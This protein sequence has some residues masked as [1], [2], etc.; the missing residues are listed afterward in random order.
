MLFVLSLGA[1]ERNDGTV[2]TAPK[3]SRQAPA[4]QSPANELTPEEL[5]LEPAPAADDALNATIAT[6]GVDEMSADVPP[7]MKPVD[8]AE[9]KT[10]R[11]DVISETAYQNEN[12]QYMVDLL[13]HDMAYLTIVVATEDGHPIRGAKPKITLAGNSR[14]VPMGE[15]TTR[16]IGEIQIGVVGGKMGSDRVEVTLG[17]RSLSVQI[18]VISL[19]AAG[20]AGLDEIEG[21]L[22]WEALTQA[23][24]RFDEKGVAAYFPPDI[25]AQNGKVVKLIGFMM[26]LVTGET[27]NHFLLTANPP[28]CFFHIPGGPAGAVEVF[29]EKGIEASWDPVVLQ[30]RFETVQNNQVGVIYRLRDARIVSK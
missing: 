12:R 4:D 20:Y 16:D 17:N 6:P 21:G 30:G 9:A 24:L 10:I 13:E 3:F 22:R 26:P 28:S 11:L 25:A 29:T 23:R 18:N 8:M 27:H 19:E 2:E 7:E 5:A 14:L 15:E 1:C